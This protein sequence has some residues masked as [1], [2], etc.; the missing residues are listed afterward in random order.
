MLAV[1]WTWA[2]WSALVALGTISLA[3]GTGTVA[4]FTLRAVSASRDAIEQQRDAIK[5]QTRE[6]EAVERQTAALADQ[7]EAVRAQAEATTR[8]AEISA[9]ALEAGSRPVLAGATREATFRRGRDEIKP[10]QDRITYL[11]GSEFLVSRNDV[12]YHEKDDKVYCSIVLRNIGAGV[13]FVQSV[14]LLVEGS[15]PFLGG[16]VSDPVIPTGGTARFYFTVALKDSVGRYTPV[17]S[18]TAS[19]RGFAKFTAYVI[20]TSAS[21]QIEMGTEVTASQVPSKEFLFTGQ[22]IFEIE[23]ATRTTLVSTANIAL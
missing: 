18:I 5:L 13:A 14:Q 19:G 15:D 7:T 6:V 8:Q 21:G 20:Y 3:I 12:H 16:R 23:G 2:G 11:D 10:E 17:R 9:A 1:F 22:E 4:W